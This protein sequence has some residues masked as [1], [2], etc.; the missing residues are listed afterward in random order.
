M[1]VPA[2]RLSIDPDDSTHFV[3]WLADQGQPA[4]AG[5]YV[6]RHLYGTYLEAVLR[7]STR[8]GRMVEVTVVPETVTRVDRTHAGFTVTGEG[9]GTVAA[10]A[11]VIAS[12][13]APAPTTLP[14]DPCLAG[15]PSLVL[16]PWSPDA[17]TPSEASPRCL[18][19]GTGLTMVDVALTLLRRPG[20]TVDAV[21]RHGVLPRSH[22]IGRQPARLP[23]RTPSGPLTADQVRS[24]LVE[25]TRNEPNG[26]AA[27][28]DL[29][30]DGSA[31]LWSRLSEAEQAKLLRR[32]TLWNIHRHRIAP[33]V[34][35]EL[36]EAMRAGRLRIHAGRVVAIARNGDGVLTAETERRRTART[37]FTADRVVV[38][39]GPSTD[40]GTTTDPLLRHLIDTGLGAIG[41]HRL[42]LAVDACGTAID[43]ND[44]PVEGLA[45]LGALRRGTVFESTAIPE[46]RAQAAALAIAL[47]SRARPPCGPRL[48]TG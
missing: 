9:G 32:G 40:I 43:R 42:G 39:T 26:W 10:R 44:R 6:P 1:N 28:V 45:I 14:I 37:E 11:V 30:R 8:T 48:H 3:R 4:Q 15:D 19:I 13:A 17:S 18:I 24:A 20:A 25:H 31:D 22:P 21:S 33:P 34:A 29:F 27:S 5:D 23:I 16:D 35:R 12:G 36:Q 7:G 38:C 47:V 46:L 41:P 2:A